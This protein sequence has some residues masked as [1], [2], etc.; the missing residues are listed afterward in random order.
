MLVVELVHD[1]GAHHLAV[2]FDELNIVLGQLSILVG[3]ADHPGRHEMLLRETVKGTR[4]WRA[5]QL[6]RWVRAP[7]VA[8]CLGCGAAL[9]FA[10]LLTMAYVL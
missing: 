7:D 4:Y 1:A 9:V 6:G 3:V 10:A 2:F 5:A 8:C